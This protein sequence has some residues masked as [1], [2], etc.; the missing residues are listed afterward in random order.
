MNSGRRGTRKDEASVEHGFRCQHSLR[1]TAPLY[2]I[3]VAITLRVMSPDLAHSCYELAFSGQTPFAMHLA[4]QP[5][6]LA[7][8]EVKGIVSAERD[9]YI[10][11]T[12]HWIH[13][14]FK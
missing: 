11:H 5:L 10:L 8:L 2:S 4:N 13:F 3:K 7:T 6:Y 1:Y 12:P 9:D 14:L